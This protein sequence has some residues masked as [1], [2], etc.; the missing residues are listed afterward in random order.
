MIKRYLTVL[1]LSLASCFSFA[2]DAAQ[3]TGSFQTA[4]LQATLE[5]MATQLET[6]LASD[7]SGLPA[8]DV[9][10]DFGADKSGRTKTTKQLQAAIDACAAKGPGRVVFPPGTYFTGTLI[11][12]SGVHLELREGVEILASPDE[13]D[14]PLISPAYKS[15]TNR[16]VNKSLFYAENVDGVSLTGDGRINF[17]GDHEV[18]RGSRNND[19]RRPFGIRFVSSRN[20]YVSGLTL[21]NSPQWMQHYL[22]CDNV[23]LDSLTIFNH[24][25]QNN[26]GI[27]IDGSR[28]VYVRN[29]KVD[30]DDDAIC[31]KSSGPSACE[32]VLIENCTVASHCN[33]L[34]LGTETTG[35]FKNIL[36]R[37]CTVIPSATGT[38]HINGVES[39]RT[40]ITLIITDGGKM[41]NVWFDNIDA[42]D[43]ITPI[44][45]TLGSR[46]R[47]HVSSASRPG[48]GSIKN[49]LISNMTATGA[50]PICSS[51]TGLDK[52]HPIDNVTLENINLEFT[53]PG[54]IADTKVDMAA[55]LKRYKPAYPSPHAWKTNLPVYGL[56]ACYINGLTLKNVNFEL[57]CQDPRKP[58]LI[59]ECSNVKK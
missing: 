9:A 46:N 31:L 29:C 1:L 22:N 58:L 40:A 37:N 19:P 17:Q 50:G 12:K 13:A 21:R 54:N 5:T 27:N 56:Y 8:F 39:T 7:H 59:E 30:T 47:R 49:I 32:N 38:R 33:A 52:D 23:M 20:I 15:Y 57:K 44:F 2:N 16:Q 3:A 42:T 35:G 11:L 41:E 45:I 14:Y 28:N 26:D 10:V 36:Y 48:I 24:A 43:C 25:N 18:Y 53:H 4:S 51:V 55:V 34:K 6:T